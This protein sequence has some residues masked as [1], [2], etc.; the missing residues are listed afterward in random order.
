MAVS[1]L[2]HDIQTF[3]IE[4]PPQFLLLASIIIPALYIIINEFVRQQ[5][6]VSGLGGPAGFPLIGHLW[7]IRRNASEKYRQWAGTYGAVYQIQLGNIP[8]VVVNSAAAAKILF[9]QNA[10]SLSSRPEF[11]TFHKVCYP[12]GS[13]VTFI[14]YNHSF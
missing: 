9:G 7:H 1:K 14:Q 12:S 6:R 3:A 8:V 10:Q 11:Y 5:A 13:L 2:I 4:S